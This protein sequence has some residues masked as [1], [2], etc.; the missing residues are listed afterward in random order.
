M[1]FRTEFNLLL[2]RKPDNADRQLDS[3]LDRLEPFVLGWL[4]PRPSVDLPELD[5]LLE[6]G[7]PDA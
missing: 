4:R 6:L 3:L 1:D 5:R 2:H 7:P